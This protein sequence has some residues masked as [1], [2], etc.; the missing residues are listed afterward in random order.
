[1]ASDGTSLARVV[2]SLRQPNLALFATG[3][4]CSMSGTWMQRLA[5]GWVTWELTE[6]T[7]WLGLIALADLFPTVVCS[8]IG[9]VLADRFNRVTLAIIT[10]WLSIAVTLALLALALL[11]LL[12][13]GLLF[14]FV[15]VSGIIGGIDH[16]IR[17]S[18][19]G[20]LVRPE[21]LA[22]AVVLSAMTFNLARMIGPALAGPLLLWTGVEGVF[23]ANALSFLAYI[24][25]ATRFDLS[26]APPRRTS[27]PQS[28]LFDLKEGVRYVLRHSELV[29][30]L[31]ILL[32]IS[33]LLRPVIELLPAFA[34][35]MA[36]HMQ[37]LPPEAVLS[38]LATILGAGALVGVLLAP[39]LSNRFGLRGAT[40][41]TACASAVL[42]VAFLALQNPALAMLMLGG[43]ACTLLAN[44]VLVQTC[45]HQSAE[46]EYRGRALS[47][48]SM[49]FRGAPAL[50]ALAI[51]SAA[52]HFGLVATVN[53]AAAAFALIVGIIFVMLKP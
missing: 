30:A 37:A 11:D 48:Q 10:Q 22:S 20:D 19:I 21:H 42:L 12:Q 33:L 7:W 47:L 13:P 27:Q 35:R 52:E 25:C 40:W 29:F 41:A 26:D 2:T 1:M 46:T 4:L 17:Q 8:P 51:G 49:I 16:P 24:W 38:M 23:V 5:V 31:T 34:A 15:L 44:A 53:S 32:A 43:F 28:V 9:G 36:P 18:L 3:T 50:G 14:A 6:S 39:S 45:V